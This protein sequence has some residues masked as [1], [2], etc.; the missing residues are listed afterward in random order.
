[1][2]S[3]STLAKITS[4]RHTSP[5]CGLTPPIGSRCG[6]ALLPLRAKW[7]CLPASPLRHQASY[8][9]VLAV[10]LCHTPVLQTL[11]RGPLLYL[12]KNALYHVVH[13]SRGDPITTLTAFMSSP[14]HLSFMCKPSDSIFKFSMGL[15]PVVFSPYRC[16]CGIG[17]NFYS[18]IQQLLFVGIVSM[19]LPS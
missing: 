4:C 12:P 3:S 2:S 14:L 13:I 17:P 11:R 9:S 5:C 6:L 18:H 16:K 1:M 7:L 8:I 10:C 19:L 15:E